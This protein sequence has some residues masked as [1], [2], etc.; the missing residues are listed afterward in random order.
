MGVRWLEVQ[1]QQLHA[2][3]WNGRTALHL[4]ADL[5]QDA[6]PCSPKQTMLCLTGWHAVQGIKIAMLSVAFLVS[7]VLGNVALKFIPVSFS[8]ASPSQFR[9]SHRL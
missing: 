4:A 1:E 6:Q 7:V 9:P 8:Q 2:W 3:G 5:G